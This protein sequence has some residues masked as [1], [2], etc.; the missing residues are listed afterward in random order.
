MFIRHNEAAT[1]PASSQPLTKY[2]APAAAF[3]S[4]L[5]RVI[6]SV[7]GNIPWTGKAFSLLHSKYT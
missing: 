3:G 1:T 6:D 5:C 7:T 4:K 2:C